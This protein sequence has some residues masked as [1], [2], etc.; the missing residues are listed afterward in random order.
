MSTT[1][2]QI[3]IMGGTSGIGLATGKHLATTGVNLCVTGR[4]RTKLQTAVAEI[5]HDCIGRAVDATD[6]QQLEALLRE[7]G[8]LDHLILTLSGG[9]G[10]G[11]FA[12]LDLEKLRQGFDA[13]F[14]PHVTTAQ[15]A[16]PHLRPNGS[17]T[18]VTAAS[19]G[20]H[21]PGTA[22]LAAINGALNA[23]IPV[24]AVELKPV[25]VNAVSP[26]VIDTAWWDKW[27]ADQK[28]ALFADLAASSPVGRVGRAEDIADAIGFLV[29]NSFIT[30]QVL[31]CDGGIQL[32]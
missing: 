30:G 3:L 25:R 17:I 6:R 14:W 13:K 24:L 23:I 12:S 4:D 1:R 29:G 32:R 28:A 9:D 18:F 20:G 21:L 22:G 31:Q 11:P 16:L 15:A 2:Q 26:G 10:A 5:G 27:P 7:I 19:A 8:S